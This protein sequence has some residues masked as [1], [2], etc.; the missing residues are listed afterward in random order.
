MQI[1]EGSYELRAEI[2]ASLSGVRLTPLA[3]W[4]APHRDTS[5]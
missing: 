5:F 4:P 2:E 3:D 1:D